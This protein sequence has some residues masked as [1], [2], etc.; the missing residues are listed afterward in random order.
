MKAAE[1]I[2][3]FY[4]K[5]IKYNYRNEKEMF[6]NGIVQLNFWKLASDTNSD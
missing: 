2:E 1:A 5:N 6:L 3:F 4:K